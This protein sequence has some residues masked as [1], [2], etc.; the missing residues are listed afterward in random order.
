MCFHCHYVHFLHTHISM[1]FMYHTSN[2]WQFTYLAYVNFNVSVHVTSIAQDSCLS[3]QR[4]CSYWQATVSVF[5]WLYRCAWRSAFQ[6]VTVFIQLR[7]LCIGISIAAFC[8]QTPNVPCRA[9]VGTHQTTWSLPTCSSKCSIPTLN[10][11]AKETVCVRDLTSDQALGSHIFAF[12]SS[13]H[14]VLLTLNGPRSVQQTVCRLWPVLQFLPILHFS[15]ALHF[16]SNSVLS[17]L[18]GHSL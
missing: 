15:F 8:A 5:S 4:S 18:V 17:A 10:E 14:F 6:F 9:C 7:S 2:L 13:Y 16:V 12:V 3:F 11:A 1:T